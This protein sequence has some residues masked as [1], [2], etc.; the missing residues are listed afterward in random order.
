[1]DTWAKLVVVLLVGLSPGIL[2]VLVLLVA[3]Y[4]E[5]RRP[6]PACSA[7]GFRMVTAIRACGR[8]GSSSWAYYYCRQCDHRLKRQNGN[9]MQPT[10]KEW[11]FH[12]AKVLR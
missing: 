4:V 12:C 3:A 2:Y 5:W 10:E 1:M 11:A 7:R 8:R 9:W 6:C